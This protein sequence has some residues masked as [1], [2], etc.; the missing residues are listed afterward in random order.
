LS[1]REGE[2]EGETMRRLFAVRA[3]GAALVLA[4]GAT[5][6]AQE[7]WNYTDPASWGTAPNS[8]YKTCATGTEQ[9]PISLKLAYKDANGGPHQGA[10]PVTARYGRPNV[11]SD[12]SDAQGSVFR[13]GVSV[14]YQEMMLTLKNTG[15]NLE[16]EGDA[17]NLF[18]VDDIDDKTKSV[19]KATYTLDNIH[20]HHPAEHF[21]T[22]AADMEMHLVHTRTDNGKLRRAV[23]AVGLKKDAADNA[24][25][26]PFFNN[27]ASGTAPAGTKI[28]PANLLPP[29]KN[30][31]ANISLRPFFRY[32]GSLTTPPCDENVVWTILEDTIPVSQAQIDAF[33]AR[34]P[35]NARPLQTWNRHILVRCCTPVRAAVALQ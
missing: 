25:L 22:A 28:N 2:G 5:A 20:F 34:Y 1:L 35:N 32:A 17:H 10:L 4:L 13:P 15:H 30:I 16:I 18:S 14:S 23:L 8:Q 31:G 3:S 27:V 26:A 7:A 9:S 12:W 33:K 24:A 6:A 29:P 11:P 19:A 21:D